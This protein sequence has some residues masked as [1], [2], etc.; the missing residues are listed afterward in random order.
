MYIEHIVIYN[1]HNVKYYLHIGYTPCIF[2]CFIYI[3][4]NIDLYK[5]VSHKRSLLK[6]KNNAPKPIFS[7]HAFCMSFE[8]GRWRVITNV[9]GTVLFQEHCLAGS[10]KYYTTVL[11][12]YL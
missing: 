9:Y 10:D 3:L 1:I 8:A 5:N 2:I 12:E 4:R 6:H 11:S 7:K